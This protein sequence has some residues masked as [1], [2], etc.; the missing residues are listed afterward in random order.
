MIGARIEARGTDRSAVESHLENDTWI[1]ALGGWHE[2]GRL[3]LRRGGEALQKDC[4]DSQVAA[5]A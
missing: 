5:I 1:T 2:R 3:V 4:S